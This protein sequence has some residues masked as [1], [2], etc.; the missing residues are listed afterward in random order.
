MLDKAAA[1]YYTFFGLCLFL[2]PVTGGILTAKFGY[3]SCCDIL[4]FVALICIFLHFLINV[5]P[6]I[7]SE[8]KRK[9]DAMSKL[10]EEIEE[11]EKIQLRQHRIQSVYT[12]SSELEDVEKM[13]E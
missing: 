1:V 12:A 3:R 6:T 4:A 5:L 8:K 11:A 7:R 9:Q 2:A 13:G 10:Q